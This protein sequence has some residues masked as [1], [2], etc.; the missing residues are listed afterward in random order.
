MELWFTEKHTPNTGITFRIKRCIY[1]K[2]TPYQQIDILES[3]EYGR[4]LLLNGI[5][6]L[7]ERDEFIYHE[8]IA[9][10]PIVTHRYP[11]HVL[12]IGG[13][14]GGTVRES[15]K[16]PDLERIELVEIDK[17][18]IDVCSEFLPAISSGLNDPKVKI[19]IDD[20][21]KFIKGQHNI[22]DAVIIDSTDPIGPAKGLFEPTFYNELFNALKPDGIMVT[23]S[24]SPF[25]DTKIWLE[26][27]R[28]I[29]CIFPITLSYLALIPT[30]PSGLW[31]FML[32]SKTYHPLQDI[33]HN[34]AKQL[35]LK[36]RYYNPGIHKSAFALPNFIKSK[37]EASL[38]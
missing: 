30:Y 29:S 31:S 16:H 7:T 22:Y 15:L 2:E 28:N 35:S 5:V 13:G 8:M 3:L 26:I 10:I 25:I 6:M 11:K 20:G 17:D 36:T 24:E 33:R 14:D 12:I 9:H 19:H 21:I 4:I 32:G 23:Q 38:K 18:V 34:Y 1:R 27:Y 37:I